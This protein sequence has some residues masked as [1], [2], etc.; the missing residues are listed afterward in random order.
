MSKKPISKRCCNF[1]CEIEKIA[2]EGYRVH[3][4]FML[5]ACPKHAGQWEDF[6]KKN[7]QYE[8]RYN[9]DF[10]VAYKEF[11]ESWYKKFQLEN[12]PPVPPKYQPSNRGLLNES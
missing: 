6:D 7:R 8:H 2:D 3:F 12:P 4:G 1:G 9:D 10:Q 5:W 11:E